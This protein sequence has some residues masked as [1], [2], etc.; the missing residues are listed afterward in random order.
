[1]I[2]KPTYEELE[3]RVKELEEEANKYKQVRN[4]LQN[5]EKKYRLI[6]SNSFIPQL[7]SRSILIRTCLT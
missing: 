6:N 3:Q 4:E 5:S 1:M 2:I 7:R